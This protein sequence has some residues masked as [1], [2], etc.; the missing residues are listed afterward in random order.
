MPQP[1]KRRNVRLSIPVVQ[2]KLQLTA[3]QW[4]QRLSCFSVSFE[5]ETPKASWA[6]L[7]ATARNRTTEMHENLTPRIGNKAVG[8]GSTLRS[9]HVDIGC[10]AS[11][12]KPQKECGMVRSVIQLKVTLTFNR[13]QWLHLLKQLLAHDIAELSRARGHGASYGNLQIMCSSVG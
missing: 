5:C 6:S 3:R 7:D 11:C 12:V 13:H 9:A 2:L 4:Y 8:F 10:H 1:S